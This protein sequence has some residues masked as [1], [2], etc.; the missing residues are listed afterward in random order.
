[1]QKKL[2]KIPKLDMRFHDVGALGGH[3][4]QSQ[5]V[6]GNVPMPKEILDKAQR[7]VETGNKPCIFTAYDDVL[8]SSNFDRRRITR[9]DCLAY[10]DDVLDGIQQ[11]DDRTLLYR[12]YTLYKNGGKENVLNDSNV[13]DEIKYRIELSERGVPSRVSAL[14]KAGFRPYTAV[15]ENLSM[16][17][18][19]ALNVPTS[20]NYIVSFDTK[21][22]PEIT[23]QFRT[24]K[25]KENLQNIGIVSIDFLQNRAVPKYGAELRSMDGSGWIKTTLD[26]SPDQLLSLSETMKGSYPDSLFLISNWIEG[27]KSSTD[28]Y[29]QGFSENE[30]QKNIEAI[31]MRICE[32]TLLREL[33]GDCD[34]TPFNVGRVY[35]PKKHIDRY[36]PDYD[37]GECF[38]GISRLLLEKDKV[39][40]CGLTPEV[41][42]SLPE[43]VRK[44]LMS[45]E[46]EKQKT[47]EGVA[48][49][50]ASGTSG[51]NV[52][53]ILSSHL[54][55]A[56][57]FFVKLEKV[58]N[59]GTFD[60]LVEKYT[61]LTA[62]GETPL[63]STEEAELTKEY[64]HI[65][66][67][68]LMSLFKQKL[69]NVD[70]PTEQM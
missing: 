2:V 67:K 35:N 56:K 15:Y 29:M 7:M 5:P 34:F 24:Q 1:M 28:K 26:Y 19:M 50:W 39:D 22:N 62:D 3:S 12:I 41:F 44:K 48:T 58:M 53:Y 59:D 6:C 20:Y 14:F 43:D 23:K 27:V 32:S 21:E 54:D 47:I 70:N 69:N 60:N 64:L 57:D 68:W 30:K 31:V 55:Y 49:S 42:N 36:A 11:L 25:K 61:M 4:G 13:V 9:E 63:L 10:I 46:S 37:Y 51:R 66:S 17:I 65:R 33:C 18:A 16:N 52:E 40:T 8:Y 38:N 45:V